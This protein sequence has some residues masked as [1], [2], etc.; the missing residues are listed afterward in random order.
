MPSPTLW[1]VAWNS[2]G[3][4][5]VLPLY[6][7]CICLND[8][9]KR[10]HTIPSNEARAFIPTTIVGSFFPLIFFAP[11]MLKWGTYHEHGYVAHYLWAT[12]LGYIIVLTIASRP[13][14]TSKKD[15]KNPDVDSIYVSMSYILAGIYAATVHAVRTHHIR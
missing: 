9:T 6:C 2:F 11:A 7:Y 1:I 3:A 8:A 15:P 10:D 12:V 5:V 4:A 14:A 13:G